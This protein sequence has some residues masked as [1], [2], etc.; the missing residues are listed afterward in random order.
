MFHLPLRL[1]VG[2]VE[3]R[4]EMR[5]GGIKIKTCKEHE[6]CRIGGTWSE[7]LANMYLMICASLQV[8]TQA[9]GG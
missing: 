6:G 2:V 9:G 3:Q 1:E 4:A 7:C 8:Y 5:G